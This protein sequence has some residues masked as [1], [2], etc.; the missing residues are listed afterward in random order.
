MSSL[1]ARNAS[2]ASSPTSLPC[3]MDPQS[4]SALVHL[5][6]EILLRITHHISTV[7]L[8]NVRL[9]CRALERATFSFF[10][11]EFFRKKQFMVS[12]F[13][14]QALLDISKHPTLSPCLKHLILSTDRPEAIGM[15]G[16]NGQPMTEE[17]SA[18]L[19]LALA[20]QMQLMTTGRLRDLLTEVF[21]NLKH[22][23]TVDIRDFDSPSRR[24][25]RTQW[26]S[27]GARTLEAAARTTVRSR[28]WIINDPYP[29]QVFTAT[30]AALAA[31]QARPRSIEVLERNRG[32]NGPFALQDAAFFI[33]G[34]IDSSMASLLGSLQSLHL[35][36]SFHTRREPFMIQKFLALATNVTWLRLNF[37]CPQITHPECVISWLGQDPDC[38]QARPFE[39]PSPK[40][41]MLE[42][43]DLGDATLSY[44]SVLRCL[45]KFAPTLKSVYLR[46]ICFQDDDN[47][48]R[49]EPINPWDSF[50]KAIP[51]TSNLDLKVLDIS[52]PRTSTY[53][54]WIDITFDKPGGRNPATQWRCTTSTL[55][56]EKA[57]EQVR[58]A[59]RIKWPT[60]EQ[61]VPTEES[62]TEE[63]EETEEE[64]GNEND[65]SEQ[66]AE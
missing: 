8:G 10:S 30:T 15:W 49:D 18:Q 53:Q 32:G 47:I 51:R 2:D 65:G 28:A 26:R 25:D 23:E 34:H 11:H 27:Y 7:D 54:W 63:S 9:T 4:T 29:S 5:P 37:H 3:A 57:I 39:T 52:Y 43:L 24:R 33:P 40:L 46:R 60:S 21:T 20:D 41:P 22:L 48:N 12:T 59:I 14:L 45:A 6:L 55:T 19:E 66:A 61:S 62:D 16:L 17:E 56:M 31:A 36:V 38:S 64:E 42:R 1:V 13:S 58:G 44:K 50:L 35:S